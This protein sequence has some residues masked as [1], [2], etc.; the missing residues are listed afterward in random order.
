MNFFFKIIIS[1]IAVFIASLI[2]SSGVQVD[3]YLYAILIALFLS[4]LNHSLKPVLILL[5]LPFT[6][7]TFGLFLLVINA[8]I[9]YIVDYFVDGFQ[10]KSIWWAILFSILTSII[11][12]ILESVNTKSSNHDEPVD[13]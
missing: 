10:V 1:S 13:L 7:V 5:T 4:I 8:I 2:L 3:S 9:I 11:N 6:I 12:S